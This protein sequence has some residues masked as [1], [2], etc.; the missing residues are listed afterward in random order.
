[1][2]YNQPTVFITILAINQDISGV[3]FVPFFYFQ[4]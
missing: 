2:L 3:E 4:V 1:M